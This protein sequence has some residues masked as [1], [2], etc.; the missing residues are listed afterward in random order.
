MARSSASKYIPEGINP[1]QGPN[2]CKRMEQEA[3][4]ESSTDTVNN[5]KLWHPPKGPDQQGDREHGEDNSDE[6]LE[7]LLITV[8]HGAVG[9]A[10]L[11]LTDPDGK[12]RR[13]V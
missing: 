4:Q 1:S 11:C 6:P 8:S 10:L 2:L 9:Q 7:H 3:L 5:Q 13:W 12:T